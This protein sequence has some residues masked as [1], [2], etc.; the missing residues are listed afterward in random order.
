MTIVVI[1]TVASSSSS[2]AIIFQIVVQR[3]QE[4]MAHLFDR[5]RPERHYMR[6]PGPKCREKRDL[7]ECA[8]EARGGS[9]VPSVR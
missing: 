6:G 8:P 2:P 4:H 9:F 1:E 5:Y 3:W 7:A